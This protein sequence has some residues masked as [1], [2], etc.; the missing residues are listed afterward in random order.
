MIAEVIGFT[1]ISTLPNGVL[2]VL[3]PSELV[4]DT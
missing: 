1:G 3:I 2:L 4:G